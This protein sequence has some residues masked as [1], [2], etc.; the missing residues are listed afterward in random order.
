MFVV[1]ILENFLVDMDKIGP[2]CIIGTPLIA[3]VKEI[4]EAVLL[5]TFTAFF[6]FDGYGLSGKKL[7][8]VK[9]GIQK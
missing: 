1:A 2:N 7:K 9:L 5:E 6:K 4:T 3:I 8:R